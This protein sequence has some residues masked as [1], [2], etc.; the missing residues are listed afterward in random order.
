MKWRQ[1][2]LLYQKELLE[3]AFSYGA[4]FSRARKQY[5]KKA[6]YI[7]RNMEWQTWMSDQKQTKREADPEPVSKVIDKRPARMPEYNFISIP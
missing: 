5:A 4:E 3:F 1:V 2:F 7:L 6:K